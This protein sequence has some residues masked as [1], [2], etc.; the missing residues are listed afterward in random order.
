MNTVKQAGATDCA[1]FA[2]A[3]MACLALEIDPLSIVLDQELLRPHLIST[4]E[5]M[6]IVPFTFCKGRRIASGVIK[7]EHNYER[8]LLLSAA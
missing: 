5:T 1:Q 6:K 8:L 7:V 2:M 3:T 4:L